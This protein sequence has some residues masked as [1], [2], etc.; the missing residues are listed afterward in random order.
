MRA[1][2]A[3][4]GLL[5]SGKDFIISE[6]LIGMV[7]DLVKMTFG[8]GKVPTA[9]TLDKFKEAEAAKEFSDVTKPAALAQ[10]AKFEKWLLPSG[11]K[12]TESGQTVRH[13]LR[14]SFCVVGHPVSSPC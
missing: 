8:G 13:D 11:D 12:F 14:R 10:L 3:Q 2:A 9:F 5:G 6:M 7:A 4:T 1:C